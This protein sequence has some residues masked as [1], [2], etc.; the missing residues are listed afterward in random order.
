MCPIC[1]FSCQAQDVGLRSNTLPAREVVNSKW[2]NAINSLNVVLGTPKA[3]G[4]GRSTLFPAANTSSRI[5]MRDVL[6]L[7][8]AIPLWFALSS[9][10]IG[11]IIGFLGAWFVTW[12]TLW[13]N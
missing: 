13:E 10:L 9:R 6:P 8:E 3:F 4:T 7:R 1:R 12:L 11:L 2:M 5:R